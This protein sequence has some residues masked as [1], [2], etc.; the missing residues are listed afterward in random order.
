MHLWQSIAT[1][2]RHLVTE[3]YQRDFDFVDDTLRSAST[4]PRRTGMDK[5]SY[6]LAHVQVEQARARLAA[7]RTAVEELREATQS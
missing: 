1:I 7:L 5:L 3:D 2:G 6:D 4:W